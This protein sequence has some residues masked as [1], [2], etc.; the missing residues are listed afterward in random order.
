M[1]WSA[2]SIFLFSHWFPSVTNKRIFC[3]VIVFGISFPLLLWNIIFLNYESFFL[4]NICYYF[5]SFSLFINNSKN[6][7]HGESL[8]TTFSNFS[9]Y[10][11]FFHFV[12]V[13]PT[14]FL[15]ESNLI[16]IF[17]VESLAFLAI[18]Y[19]WCRLGRCYGLYTFLHLYKF[20]CSNFDNSVFVLQLS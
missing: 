3:P 19:C 20:P 2:Y 5:H 8:W 16:V 1:N 7:F 18:P 10:N 13:S 11:V 14:L 12:S 4:H 15:S 9:A 17:F 6:G